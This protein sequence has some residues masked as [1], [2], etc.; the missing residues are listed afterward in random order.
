MNLR[1]F[2][3]R[4]RLSAFPILLALL[5]AGCSPGQPSTPPATQVPPSTPVPTST[6][7]PTST[8][9]SIPATNTPLLPSPTTN[10]LQGVPVFT[11]IVLRAEDTSSGEV[12]YQDFFFKDPDGDVNFIDYEVVSTTAEN[13]AVQGGAVNV[14][15]ALQKSGGETTG[16]WNCG[17]WTYDV[18][19]RATLID[20]KG[21]RSIT[22]L[23]TMRCGVKEQEKVTVVV[24]TETP[25]SKVSQTPGAI[26]FTETPAKCANG[27]PSNTWTL[28]ITNKSSQ[29]KN[30]KI[31]GK[32]YQVPAASKIEVYL[33]LDI[34]HAV[35]F[36]TNTIN[37]S[38][39]VACGENTFNIP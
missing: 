38:N 33:S 2:P 36:G 9:T 32:T 24:A 14:S 12:I 23:Y 19:L 10:P 3:K 6:Q 7:K 11:S 15:A 34:Q 20:S 39:N 28:T 5:V 22:Q 25:S 29:A 27:S 26:P 4:L 8:P 17:E 35:M 13:V 18:T 37:F 16:T 30:I 1:M 31:D 21:F